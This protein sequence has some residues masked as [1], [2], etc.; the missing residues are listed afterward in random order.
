MSLLDKLLN[1]EWDQINKLNPQGIFEISTEVCMHQLLRKRINDEI[2]MPFKNF[3]SHETKHIQQKG[4]IPVSQISK[5]LQERLIDEAEIGVLSCLR[6]KPWGDIGFKLTQLHL[7]ADC[8]G[9]IAITE[10]NARIGK[11][12]ND[13][14][15]E[16]GYSLEREECR[17]QVLIN[18]MYFLG[19][20]DPEFVN[21]ISSKFFSEKWCYIVKS[22]PSEY[23]KIILS[24]SPKILEAKTKKEF[25]SLTKPSK[26]FIMSIAG[27][28]AKKLNEQKSKETKPKERTKAEWDEWKKSVP[29]SYISAKGLFEIV[30]EIAIKTGVLYKNLKIEPYELKRLSK[31][32]KDC[33]LDLLNN[34]ALVDCFIYAYTTVLSA[35]LIMQPDK[36]FGCYVEKEFEKHFSKKY[37]SAIGQTGLEGENYFENSAA[38]TANEKQSVGDHWVK[39]LLLMRKT[40]SEYSKKV[41]SKKKPDPV[42]AFDSTTVLKQICFSPTWRTTF[43]KFATE[44]EKICKDKIEVLIKKI[45]WERVLSS[46]RYV[47]ADS[48]PDN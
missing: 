5:D 13:S 40:A 45:N 26:K 48:F 36:F 17:V 43:S 10:N 46:D 28:V 31:T 30:D 2:I 32:K 7:I 22:F 27:V 19:I 34:G 37:G 41:I 14:L 29:L 16:A 18:W 12:C 47:S 33:P 24:Y 21:L 1:P 15:N 25:L 35:A 11:E 9:I 38:D 39:A 23:S 42:L 20:D 44:N 3:I 4:G 8:V 6:G